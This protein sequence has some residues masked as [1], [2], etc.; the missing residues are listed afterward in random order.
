MKFYRLLLS[1]QHSYEFKNFFPSRPMRLC[2]MFHYIREIHAHTTHYPIN[3]QKILAECC[4]CRFP[5][6]WPLI[7]LTNMADMV[8]LTKVQGQ[9]QR[10]MTSYLFH[11][12]FILLMDVARGHQTHLHPHPMPLVHMVNT[13]TH[14]N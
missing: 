3:K 4:L 7:T 5:M 14:A 11:H 10:N 6:E 2:L 1:P 12:L 9:A 13:K 8:I